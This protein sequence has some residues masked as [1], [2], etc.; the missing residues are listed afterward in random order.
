[1]TDRTTQ[2]SK[3][4]SYTAIPAS[5][6][7]AA[8]AAFSADPAARMAE[9]A[10]SASPIRTVARVPKALAVDAGT[11]DVQL[12]Q[13]DICDQKRSGRCWMFASL[14]TMRFRI[15]KKLNLKT[16]ELS[17][18]YPLFWDKYE[19]ANWFFQNI[20]A[21]AN[22]PLTS[23]NVSF[24]LLD[25][26]CDGGQWDM[27]RSIVK[28]Y[29]VVPKD[30][31]PETQCSSNTT[32]MNAFLTRFL[33]ASAKTLREMVTAGATADKLAD[34]QAELLSQFYRM[35]AICLGEPPRTFEARIRDKDDALVVSGTYTPSQ[36]FDEF[37]GMNLDDYVSVINAPTADKPY[38]RS[39]SVKFLGNVAEDGGVRYVNLPA[40]SLKR[41]AIA[42]L[43]DGL[44]VWFGCDV[45]QNYLQD[46]AMMGIDTLDVD[47]LLGVNVMG[48]LDK[49]ARLD[50]GES[51]MTHAM[52]FQ[53]V[54][55]DAAGEPSLWRVENSWGKKHGHD[56]YD[57][58]TDDWFSEYVYQVV[59][60]K[61]YLTDE[62]RTAY[63]GEPTELAPWDPMGALAD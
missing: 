15:M 33:R 58:M 18:A 3:P 12:S 41:A 57:L 60:D 38:M 39:Y 36:F 55:F 37:V 24:L 19:R 54:N 27:F 59:V 22:E 56:G 48:S 32:D 45:D 49:A 35:L 63:D 44:P 28:K 16:F 13:G 42:Q 29:G 10:V 8:S 14:N 20:I 47:G 34:K 31:M 43:K 51:L 7:E 21:T 4:L 30:A 2:V 50:Y 26:L 62:E 23:R 25:P 40:E 17:Q 53:G 46:D 6:T 61:K 5:A 9:H 11:F 52:V 1:M